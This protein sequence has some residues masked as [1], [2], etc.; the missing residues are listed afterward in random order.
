M[1]WGVAVCILTLNIFVTE[2]IVPSVAL[3]PVL[4]LIIWQLSSTSGQDAVNSVLFLFHKI[5]IFHDSKKIS[6][7]YSVGMELEK[8]KTK[9]AKREQKHKRRTWLISSH[10]DLALGQ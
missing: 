1:A 9:S 10:L 7:D 6:C 3:L 4:Q 2:E 8:E 5:I